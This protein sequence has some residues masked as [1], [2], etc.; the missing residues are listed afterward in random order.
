MAMSATAAAKRRRAGGLLSSPMLQ[1]PHVL[2]SMPANRLISTLQNIQQDV[3]E[4]NNNINIQ[5]QVEPNQP[6][7]NM[8]GGKILTLQQVIKLLDTRI[9]NLE[10]GT[11]TEPEPQPYPQPPLVEIN[12]T[13]IISQCEA[14]VKLTLESSIDEIISRKMEEVEINTTEIISQCEANVKL[15]LESSMNEIISRK[16]EEVKMDM[17][18]T[19][20][21]MVLQQMND[22]N[23]RY[24][25]LATE[26]L[27]VK[28]LLL[29]LQNYTMGVNKM[30]IEERINIFSEVKTDQFKTTNDVVKLCEDVFVLNEVEENKIIEE[31]I[32]EAL[33]PVEEALPPVEEAL[34]PVEEALPPL[35]EALP[36]VEE[37]LPPV[38]EALPPVEEILQPVEEV[39]KSVL[40]NVQCVEEA[41]VEKK[42]T[43]DVYNEKTQAILNTTVDNNDLKENDAEFIVVS[44]K[45]KKG[46][47][48]KNQKKKNS[49][50]VEQEVSLSI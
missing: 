28:N 12:T 43:I 36:P 1:P 6:V 15:T 44:A 20:E 17:L 34:L 7:N 4:Q 11:K 48:A 50:N 30:L 22:F 27:N 24:E 13:E 37:A 25:I 9:I 3:T 47:N 18:Q 45:G 26:I 8:E 42:F 35:E 19:T 21:A 33:P 32:E 10:K 5:R 29:E 39:E 16:M 31:E 46:K 49:V 14:N 2:Q 41:I 38:E 23:D 40:D